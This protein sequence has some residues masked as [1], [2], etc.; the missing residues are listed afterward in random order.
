M[1]RTGRILIGGGKVL[2]GGCQVAM[3][4]TTALGGGMLGTLLFAHGLRGVAVGYGGT[5]AQEGLDRAR[6][7]FQDIVSR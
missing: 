2:A 7:G 5:K 1:E 3:G 6:E 4:V